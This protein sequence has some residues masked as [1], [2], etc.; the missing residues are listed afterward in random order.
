MTKH[1]EG[2]LDQYNRNRDFKDH[3]HDMASYNRVMLELE[4]KN[5]W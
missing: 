5:I 3:I 2:L 1:E 4:I